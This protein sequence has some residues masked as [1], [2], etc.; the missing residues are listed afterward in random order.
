MPQCCLLFRITRQSRRLW[1][2]PNVG[3]A[4]MPHA[5]VHAHAHGPMCTHIGW[6]AI[7]RLI[8]SLS[9]LVKKS[10]TLQFSLFW[11]TLEKEKLFFSALLSQSSLSTWHHCYRYWQHFKTGFEKEDICWMLSPQIP[12]MK[13]RLNGRKSSE[14]HFV[15]MYKYMHRYMFVCLN[16]FAYTFVC[17]WESVRMHTHA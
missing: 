16:V 5:C 11:W 13:G 9:L 4:V 12:C 14:N 6:S 17:A 1:S 8:Y 10:D 2:M 3:K 7:L 15:S